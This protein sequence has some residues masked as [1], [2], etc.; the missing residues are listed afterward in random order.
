MKTSNLQ[1]FLSVLITYACA[2]LAIFQLNGAS[3]GALRALGQQTGRVTRVY[4]S[5][6]R[7]TFAGSARGY[8]GNAG[9]GGRFGSL[10]PI[11]LTDI[12]TALPTLPTAA[13]IR[14]RFGQLPQEAWQT[15]RTSYGSPERTVQEPGFGRVAVNELVR[16]YSEQIRKDEKIYSDMYR[17]FYM[18]RGKLLRARQ[19]QQ[20]AMQEASLAQRIFGNQTIRDL[21][22]QVEATQKAYT[23]HSKKMDVQAELIQKLKK[24]RHELQY[25]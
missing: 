13:E 9:L 21:T 23:E 19:A 7:S 25:R 5:P 15:I 22:A 10:E 14:S 11:S 12:Q 1:R 17:T 6:S 20:E 3:I 24:R 2:L 16:L 18:L 4:F 8:S